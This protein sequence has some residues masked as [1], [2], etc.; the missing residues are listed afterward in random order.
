MEVMVCI[1]HPD[2]IAYSPCE[3]CGKFFCKECL[4]L[5]CI[6]IEYE[7]ECYCKNPSC[8]KLK[9]LP[10][11]VICPNCDTE[12]ELSYDEQRNKRFHCEV[13]EAF[14]DFSIDPT[15]I[16]EKDNFVPFFSTN[17]QGNIAVL[18]SILD[19]AKIE[20][21]VFDENFLSSNLI[22]PARFFVRTDQLKEAKEILNE[23]ELQI[24]GI[25]K[26]DEE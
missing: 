16:I 11:I 21:Y 15:K 1:N 19:N 7:I 23:C 20:Y 17:N 26:G 5:D 6:R 22:A 13:C 10:E 18:K 4:D 24:W 8:Q 3:G 14:I 12:L 9:P 25:S 2:K